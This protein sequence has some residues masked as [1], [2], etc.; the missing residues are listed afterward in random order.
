MRKLR[1]LVES[2]RR[3][4]ADSWAEALWNRL[5]AVDFANQGM[6]FAGTLLLCF[7]PFMLV[8]NALAGRT[9]MEGMVR[10]MGLN[11]EAAS[12]V[13]GLIAPAATTSSAVGGAS[14]VFFVVGG[15]AGVAALQELYHRVFGLSGRPRRNILRLVTALAVMIGGML[16]AGWASRALHHLGGP[17]LLGTVAVVAVAA[18]WWLMM[19]ILL[20]RRVPWR[21]LLPCAWATS[22]YY[23]GMAVVFSFT[24]SGM[25]TSNAREYGPIGVVFAL[26]SWLIALGVVIILGAVTGTVWQQ[27]GTPLPAV[28]ARLRRVRKRDAP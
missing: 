16:L 14:S 26:M 8:A 24:A 22:V 10:R 9:A 1:R 3:R 21:N 2:G 27:R 12:D 28:S 5:Q 23:V 18:F 25:I 7:V 15:I 17:V 11:Q 20:G 13:S 19:R 4:Y 6:V